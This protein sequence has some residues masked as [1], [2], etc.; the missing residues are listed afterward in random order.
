MAHDDMS[1]LRASVASARTV[2][3]S[4][5]A[6]IAGMAERLRNA[7]D[8]DD[9]DALNALADELASEADGLAADVAANTSAQNEPELPEG[10]PT[11]VGGEGD[12]TVTEPTEP[13][14][15]AGEPAPDAPAEPTPPPA[16]EE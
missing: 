5:R 14:P 11:V 6:L 1:K 12:D 10:A 9:T 13:E 8:E 15:P 16:G 3:A 2:I 7:L 4:A